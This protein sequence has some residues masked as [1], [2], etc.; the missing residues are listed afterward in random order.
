MLKCAL[1]SYVG[2]GGWAAR[3]EEMSSETI[4]KKPGNLSP[5]EIGD[6]ARDLAAVA[7][8]L[9]IAAEE[10]FRNHCIKVLS[11]GY[12][13]PE[14]DAAREARNVWWYMMRTRVKERED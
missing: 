2:A 8:E 9:Q 11:D 4:K 3:E 6:L 12:G 10:S 14:D 7:D 13:V 5:K 1:A